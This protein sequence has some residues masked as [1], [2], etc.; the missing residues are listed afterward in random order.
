[1]P[2]KV[3]AKKTNKG[4]EKAAE[5]SK[6]KADAKKK[7]HEAKKTTCAVCSLGMPNPATYKQHFESKHPKSPLPDELK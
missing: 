3:A 5:Q 6:A 1:M 4:S 7:G 2:P